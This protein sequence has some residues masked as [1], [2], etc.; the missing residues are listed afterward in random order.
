MF[1]GWLTS[2]STPH[3]QA[4]LGLIGLGCR[5]SVPKKS[6]YSPAFYVTLHPSRK[7]AGFLCDFTKVN[8]TSWIDIDAVHRRRSN[9]GTGQSTPRAK[10][11]SA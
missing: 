5:N 10:V 3:R 2:L 6:R 7:V 8:L 9:V 11:A 1:N 4:R